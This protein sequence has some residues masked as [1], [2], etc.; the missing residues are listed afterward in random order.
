MTTVTVT[1]D[2]PYRNICSDNGMKCETCANSPR[3]SY[4]IPIEP[5][6]PY[7][8]YYPYYQPTTITWYTTTSGETD[9]S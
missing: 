6:Y 4:Y 3:R 2:C 1:Y 8:T 9:D 7:Y 5:Y